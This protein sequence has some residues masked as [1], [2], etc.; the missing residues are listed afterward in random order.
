MGVGDPPQ[1]STSSSGGGVGIVGAL[2][3]LAGTGISAWSNANQNKKSRRFAQMQANKEGAEYWMKLDEQRRYED[4]L[5]NRD[6][7][8][9]EGLWNK[10]NEYNERVWQMQNQ[11]NERMRDE[12]RMYDSPMAQMARFKE[13]GLNPNLIYGQMGGAGN[14]LSG[15]Q[16]DTSNIQSRGHGS[17]SGGSVSKPQ[18]RGT[19]FSPD[20]GGAISSYVDLNR[21][22]V[23]TNN[24]ERI[25]ELVKEQVATQQQETLSKQLENARRTRENRLGDSLFNTQVDAARLQVKK[26]QQDMD[27]DAGRYDM[28]K[29]KQV[30]EIA[31]MKSQRDLNE[32]E[33]KLKSYELELRKMGIYQGDPG[34]LRLMLRAWDKLEDYS[35]DPTRVDL[36]D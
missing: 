12:Q 13:A 6:N 26:L 35:G 33:K 8:Y 4:E 20:I 22:A 11:Y 18:W 19:P 2:G 17:V 25:N 34:W 7:Q 32:Q 5:W 36:R 24:L 16:I 23:E 29:V 30:E 9:F 28:Q 31:N 1:S 3:S 15:G 21:K 10:Q 14:P 27:L